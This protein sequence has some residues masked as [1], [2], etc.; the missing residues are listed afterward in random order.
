MNNVQMSEKL[1]DK[2]EQMNR[3]TMSTP[4]CRHEYC[5]IQ[6]YDLKKKK[7]AL[8]N[9]EREFIISAGWQEYQSI[10]YCVNYKHTSQKPQGNFFHHR[11]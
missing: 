9:F 6:S 1:Q 11:N 7:K 5:K 3:K 4:A 10:V 8:Y 2:T